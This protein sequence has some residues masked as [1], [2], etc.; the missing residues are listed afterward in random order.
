MKRI[1]EQ[2]AELVCHPGFLVHIG[3]QSWSGAEQFR[4]LRQAE[5]SEWANGEFR[6]GEIYFI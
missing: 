4:M 3:L 1:V 6:A 2:E 5:A